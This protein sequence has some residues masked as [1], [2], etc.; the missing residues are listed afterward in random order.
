ML[1]LDLGSNF[2]SA[3]GLFDAREGLFD[4]DVNAD[5]STVNVRAQISTTDDNPSGS[6]VWTDW[7]DFVVGDVGGRGIR[8]RVILES[9]NTIHAPALLQLRAIVDMPDRVESGH[10]LA[11]STS[12]GTRTVTF[13][14]AFKETPALGIAAVL[15]SGD[16]YVITS[17][18]RTG[19]TIT[20]YTGNTVSTNGA[21]VDYVAKGYGRAVV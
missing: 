11:I 2:D 6:P 16:R 8:F 9:E 21:T 5:T 10:D 17:K 1:F 19:F 14:V 18:S 12:T 15:A 3:P 13:P 20:I 7:R 4:G